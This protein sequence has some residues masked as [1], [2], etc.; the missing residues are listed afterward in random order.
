LVGR[1]GVDELE[2]IAALLEAQGYG[3]DRIVIDPSVVRG[4]G[5]YTGPVFEAE[6]TFEI[7][8]EKGRPRQ[9]GSV[10]G[11]GRYDDL[12]KRFTGQAVPATGISIGVDRLLAALR[13]KGRIGGTAEG[14]VVVTVMDRD[15]MADYQAMAAE[16]RAAGIRAEVYLGNPKNF[17]NQLK[18]ADK[19]GSPVAIIE[20]G[21]EKARG[22][23]QV[24]DLILGARIAETATH[25]EWKDQPAQF[26]CPRGDIVSEV[27]RILGRT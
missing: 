7:L 13:A 11:G 26:E 16:L 1:E 4:L 10:A 24:K 25:E 17:G 27:R 18:Y 19:R 8:D 20:G 9:F 14:P 15:R 3:P 23:V 2:E 5:Y 22:V 21:D 12:V 6:L